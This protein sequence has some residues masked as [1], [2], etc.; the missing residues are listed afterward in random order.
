M[1]YLTWLL[2]IVLFIALLGFA[3]KNNDPVALRYFFGYEWNTT[4]VVALLSFFALGAGFG[5]LAMLPAWFRLRVELRSA[6]QAASKAAPQADAK[7]V[8]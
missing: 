7:Q 3:L 2:R 5:I 4:L 1:P 6:R 8:I